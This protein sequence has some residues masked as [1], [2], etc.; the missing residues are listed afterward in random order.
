MDSPQL[1]VT[2]KPVLINKNTG[3]T[4]KTNFILLNTSIPPLLLN[5]SQTN[6]SQFKY[7]NHS[8]TTL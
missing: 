3:K 6:K 5:C 1:A 4:N 2:A 7:F 8:N